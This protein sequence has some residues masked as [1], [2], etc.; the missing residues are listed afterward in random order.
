MVTSNNQD[1]MCS[2]SGI[3]IGLAG[4]AKKVVIGPEIFSPSHAVKE[5]EIRRMA[6]VVKSE[7]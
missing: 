1:E 5:K 2:Y 6:Q 4:F 7:R 3:T